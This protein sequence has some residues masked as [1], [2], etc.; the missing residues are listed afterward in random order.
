MKRIPNSTAIEAYYRLSY[1]EEA[2]G[3]LR[4]LSEDEGVLFAEIGKVTVIL[5]LEVEEELQPL[6]GKKIGILHTDIPGKEYLI[7]N[8]PEE[9]RESEKIANFEAVGAM[10]ASA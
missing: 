1:Y 9:A 10:E 4:K 3:E 2:V 8:F 5:P 6:L 7:R